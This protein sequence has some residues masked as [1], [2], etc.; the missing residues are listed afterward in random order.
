MKN[1]AGA[2]DPSYRDLNTLQT[3]SLLRYDF[4]A[5]VALKYPRHSLAQDDYPYKGAVVTPKILRSFCITKYRQWQ[6]NNLVQDPG[7]FFKKNLKINV[8]INNPG[9]VDIKLPVHVMGQWR[10]THTT[11]NFE[12]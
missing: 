7:G 3:L 10:I 2:T 9:Q 8:D 11:L 5:S 1:D 4:K 6:E 12:I